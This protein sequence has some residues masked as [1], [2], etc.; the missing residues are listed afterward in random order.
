MI[1]TL[2][3]S[4]TKWY[5]PT[6]ADWVQVYDQPVVNLANKGY[7]NQNIY[8]TLVN[9]SDKLT[10]SDEVNIMWAENHRLDLWYDQEWINTKD[11]MGF[12]PD[13]NGKLWFSNTTPYM[14]LYR[15]HPDLYTSFTNM[16]IETL[17]IILQTQLLLDRIGCKYVMHSSKNLWC[18]GRPIFLPKY[19]T[20]YQ[21]KHGI[22]EEELEI[23]TNIMLLDPVRKLIGL[24]DWS[25]FLGKMTNPFDAKQSQGIWEYYI[26]NREVVLLKHDTDH[27]PNSLAHHDYAV[28]IVLK[29]NPKLGKFRSVAEQIAKET[30]SY[31]IPTFT[32]DEYIIKS[33]VGLL[34]NKYKVL[35]EKLK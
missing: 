10:T 30:T 15:T 34:D 26:N 16:V 18:D 21:H 4:M 8:W 27:H 11:V 29:K 22:S 1:Y 23:A 9:L 35:L 13:T 5:W 20:T 19:Q 31:S 12:F 2:G 7:G 17:Q 14:G 25:K 32:S 3:C 33:D 28:E 24:I 6:W